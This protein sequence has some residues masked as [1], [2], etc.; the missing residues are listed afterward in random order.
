MRDEFVV[1]LSKRIARHT[2]R[3]QEELTALEQRHKASTEQLL[4]A[5]RDVLTVPSMTGSSPSG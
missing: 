5:Y 3:A 4:V 1:M 2:K